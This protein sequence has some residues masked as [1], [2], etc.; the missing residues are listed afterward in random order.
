MTKFE[1]KIV[2]F[3]QVIGILVIFR[4]CLFWSVKYFAQPGKFDPVDFL[5]P[6]SLSFPTIYNM[7]IY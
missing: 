2:F 1:A 7:S 3:Q 4:A 6:E 5:N